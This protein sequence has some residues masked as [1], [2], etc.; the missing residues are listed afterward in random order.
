MEKEKE[1]NG[2]ENE[3]NDG[4]K[5]FIQR[6]RRVISSYLHWRSFSYPGFPREARAAANPN[7]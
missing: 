5:M 3:E 7:S 4:R 2:K 6:R 1:R